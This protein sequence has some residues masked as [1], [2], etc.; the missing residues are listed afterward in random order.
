MLK[1]VRD[2]CSTVLAVV[3]QVTFFLGVA[4]TEGRLQLADLA[5][6]CARASTR[7]GDVKIRLLLTMKGI[8]SQIPH[9]DPTE[10]Q[11]V[12]VQGTARWQ[13]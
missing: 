4:A 12:I 9:W 7:V 5:V 11:K 6:N 10:L 2:C 13:S 3:E 8:V 1:C